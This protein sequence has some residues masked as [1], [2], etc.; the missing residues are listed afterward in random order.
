M[1]IFRCEGADNVRLLSLA[2]SAF[3]LI[4][5]S[6]STVSSDGLVENFICRGSYSNVEFSEESGDG[7]GIFFQIDDVGRP[8]FHSWEGE[9]F[10]AKLR[11][12][13]DMADLLILSATFDEIEGDE[14]LL[15][16]RCRQASVEFESR[17]WG[18]ESLRKLNKSEA[19]E[20][21]WNP[22]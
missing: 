13:V 14:S 18:K 19:E 3:A 8:K 12:E 17:D 11:V 16:F 2:A 15:R 21:D 10:R 7:S 4:A 22:E 20:L 5:C 9:V 1:I 6:E